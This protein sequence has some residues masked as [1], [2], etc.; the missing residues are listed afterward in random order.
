M[1]WQEGYLAALADVEELVEAH[2]LWT[3]MWDEILEYLRQDAAEI[4]G[5][6]DDPYHHRAVVS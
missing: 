3:V 1:K 5:S 6:G 2:G 4:G